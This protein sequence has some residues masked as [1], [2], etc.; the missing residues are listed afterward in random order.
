MGNGWSKPRKIGRKKWPGTH[1]EVPLQDLSMSGPDPE[2]PTN[3]S[4]A[5]R[6][7]WPCVQVML[8]PWVE[9]SKNQ[10]TIWGWLIPRDITNLW[11]GWFIDVYCWLFHIG[12]FSIVMG[13]SIEAMMW[14]IHCNLQSAP[15]GPNVFTDDLRF[16][17]QAH[18]VFGP[19]VL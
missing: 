19:Q 4:T 1:L 3:A 5:A 9:F 15:D 13:C 11:W 6:Y 17:Q 8:G 14:Y 7:L 12:E 16:W 2:E 10:P 18:Q